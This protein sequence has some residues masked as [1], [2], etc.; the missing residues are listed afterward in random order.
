MNYIN[1][2]VNGKTDVFGVIGDPISHTYSPIIQN[3]I[4]NGLK[5][6]IMYVPFHVTKENL[7]NAIKG[8]YSLEIKGLNVTVPHKKSVMEF[9]TSIDSKAE[10]IGAVNTLK[11]TNSGYCGYNT[12]ILGILH[13]FKAKGIE[14][15]DKTVLIL[16]AGGSACSAAVMA[17]SQNA[18][19][20]IIAN[21]TLQN[22]ESLK[23]KISV[24]YNMP[25]DAINIDNIYDIKYC[26]IVIQTTTLGF[27]SNIGINPIKD[28]NFFK[29]KNV[30]VAFD[31][32][33]IPWKTEFLKSAEEMNCVCINGFDMLF[34]QAVAAQ[35]IWFDTTFDDSFKEE[36]KSKIA[37]YF[38]SLNE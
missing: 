29:D 25:I 19:R 27:S 14:I 2:C 32:I 8:A 6:N 13:S 7:E 9:L 10:Q 11:Y 31:T 35:E 16:G 3:T 15:K 1:E 30:Q 23:Q 12:D 22:A 34:Y 38:K 4:A 33:Y 21:R 26:D 17:A 37:K 24:Y 36:Y 20:I 18:K 28:I 5:K